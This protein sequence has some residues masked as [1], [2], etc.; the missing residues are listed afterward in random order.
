LQRLL[1]SLSNLIDRFIKKP[2]PL[3]EE[4][5]FHE[6]G[7]N[8]VGVFVNQT[9]APLEYYIDTILD[10]EANYYIRIQYMCACG[11]PCFRLLG[12]DYG[13]GCDHCDSVCKDEACTS[14]Y[15]LMSVDFGA[16]GGDEDSNI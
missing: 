14:C 10:E 16:P 1:I 12:D 5:E 7:G 6:L 2:E 8:P 4:S 9:K 15:N 11:E 3:V 13:F